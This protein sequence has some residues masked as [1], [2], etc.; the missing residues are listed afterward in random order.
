MCESKAAI[1]AIG[2]E[3]Q[4]LLPD[5]QLE[6]LLGGSGRLKHGLDLPPSLHQHPY[7]GGQDTCMCANTQ[8]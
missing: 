1:H 8:S 5:V 2:R 4:R 3:L 7:F 6:A